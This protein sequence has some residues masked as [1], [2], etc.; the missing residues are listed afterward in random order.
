LGAALASLGLARVVGRDV[1]EV[2]AAI[3][4]A[5]TPDGVTKEEVAARKAVSD[6]LERLYERFIDEGRDL[7]A[8]ESMTREDAADAIASCVEAYIFNRWLGDL[9]LKIE[10]RAVSASEAVTLEREIREFIH[11]TV[12]LDLT[13]INVLTLD[14]G[15]EQG[16]SFVENIYRDAY[17]LFGGEA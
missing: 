4:N 15:G 8:L 12:T 16:R 17:S 2:L 1:N 6:T 9:G 11:A 7:S 13:N 5:L 10:E 14:W 3:V